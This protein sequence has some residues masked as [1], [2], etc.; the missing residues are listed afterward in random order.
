VEAVKDGGRAARP[1]LSPAAGDHV[2]GFEGHQFCSMPRLEPDENE[3]ERWTVQSL[4]LVSL[5]KY[6]E[7][8]VY[9]SEYLPRMDELREAPTRK[10]N[11][12]E[13]HALASLRRGEDLVV[14]SDPNEIRMLG[15]IRAVNVCTSC[16][17]ANRSD[18][19]GA[20]SYRLR[21]Q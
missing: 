11:S 15:S 19:L 7:S 20:F 21:L 3:I 12:F 6:A 9:L 8:A 16:H 1:A 17:E 13:L 4:E 2:K 14:E 18:L 10:L 5:L